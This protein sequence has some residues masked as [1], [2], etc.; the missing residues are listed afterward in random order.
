MKFT[1]SVL[2]AYF[3]VHDFSP[4]VIGLED[5]SKVIPK[6]LS[7]P[8]H[9]SEVLM[10]NFWKNYWK[11]ITIASLDLNEDENTETIK[12]VIN[13]IEDTGFEFDLFSQID[14]EIIARGLKRRV[15]TGFIHVSDNDAAMIKLFSRKIQID[16]IPS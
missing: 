8:S 1:H 6:H 2:L 15:F 10:R 4:I 12:S 16:R 3:G 11:E 5:R 9:I 14:T 7:L 13:F